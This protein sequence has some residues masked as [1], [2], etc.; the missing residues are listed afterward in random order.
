MIVRSVCSSCLQTY[1]LLIQAS[2]VDLVKQISTDEGRTCPCPRLCGGEINL[3]GSPDIDPDIQLRDP[4]ELTGLQLYQS[5]GGLGLPDEVPK[6]VTVIDSIFKAY[7]VLSIDVEEGN[8]SFYLNEIRFEGG[9]VI[10]LASGARGAKVLK[11]T[12]E[13]ANGS[14]NPG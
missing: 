12:K 2:D 13:K 7:K 6:D 8:G 11:I 14:V 3:T 1:N 9:V 4:I 5:V 10:H